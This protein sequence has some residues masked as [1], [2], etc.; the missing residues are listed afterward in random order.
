MLCHLRWCSWQK[1]INRVVIW[2]FDNMY[3]EEQC[4]EYFRFRKEDMPTLLHELRL[5]VGRDGRL[6]T[7]GRYVFE[8]MEALCTFLFRMAHAG[9]WYIVMLAMGGASAARYSGAFYF[10]LDHIYNTFKKCIDN[11]GRWE[12]N[13]QIFAGVARMCLACF[14]PV[15]HIPFHGCIA[16]AIRAAGAPVW[17]CIGFLDGTFRPCARPV[18]GQR[19]L[20]SGYKKAHGFHFQSVIGPNGLIIDLFGVCLGKHSDSYLLRLSNLVARLQSL[21]R[22][23]GSHFYVYADSAYT[24]SMY[25]LRAFKGAM[26]AL[27][28]LFNTG[29]SGVR[30]SVEWGF[31][32]VVNDWK[33]LDEKKNLKLYKQ[34]IAKIFYV[35]ALL[36]NMKCCLTAAHTNDGYGNQIAKFFGVS[37]PSLHDYL[38]NF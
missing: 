17:R 2:S 22:G 15:P 29:M 37:P 18:R 38:H 27:Q 10:V 14:R 5:P 21:T 1:G 30:I 33:F 25:I 7:A 23:E 16:D 32:L 28:Q 13:S 36:S 34:P 35:G 4:W 20:Y 3:S 12:G 31:G 19:G 11:I 24:L 8:P 6:C 9:P 26:T